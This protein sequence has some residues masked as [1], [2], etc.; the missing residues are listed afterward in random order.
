MAKKQAARKKPNAA[1]LTMR[2]LRA[3]VKR[4]EETQQQ[5]ANL[6]LAHVDVTNRCTRLE[7]ALGSLITWTAQSAN[8]PFSQQEAERLLRILHGTE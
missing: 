4:H 6:A 1:D 3:A 5:L 8:S 2:N 7:N